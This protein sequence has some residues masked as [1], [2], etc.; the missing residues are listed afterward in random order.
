LSKQLPNDAATAAL[1]ALSK[2]IQGTTVTVG[3]ATPFLAIGLGQLRKMI[4][5]LQVYQNYL[6]FWTEEE[7]LPARLEAV[8]LDSSIF[9]LSMGLPFYVFAVA[10]GLLLI[11]LLM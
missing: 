9:M 1:K 7:D 11:A 5:G 3:V 10:C 2:T 8:G 6:W 4:E